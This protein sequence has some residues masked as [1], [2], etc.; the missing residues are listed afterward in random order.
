MKFYISVPSYINILLS[1]EYILILVN[2]LK[3]HH[4]SKYI[5]LFSTNANHIIILVDDI[6]NSFLILKDYVVIQSYLIQ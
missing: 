1:H 6:I 3:S 4:I 5:E 2:L